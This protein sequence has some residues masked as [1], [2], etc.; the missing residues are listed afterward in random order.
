MKKKHYLPVPQSTFK[1]H[2]TALRDGTSHTTIHRR[3]TQANMLAGILK[4]SGGVYI[5]M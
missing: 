1:L 2:V 5:P 4:F 3:N